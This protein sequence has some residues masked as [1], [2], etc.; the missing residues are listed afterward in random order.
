MDVDT[1][2]MKGRK[3]ARVIEERKNR[4]AEVYTKHEAGTLALPEKK[5][6]MIT[7]TVLVAPVFKDRKAL[8]KS[9]GLNDNTCVMV[10]LD[11][12]ERITRANSSV[13]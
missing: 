11:E 4:M 2:W 3:S 8:G 6:A 12:T 9:M 5:P 13:Y 10:A 1:S 7:G